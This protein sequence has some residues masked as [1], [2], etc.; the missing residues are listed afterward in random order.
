MSLDELPLES[1]ENALLIFLVGGGGGGAITLFLVGEPVV[2]GGDHGIAG[3]ELVML[4]KDMVLGGWGSA[5]F[6]SFFG[7]ESSSRSTLSKDATEAC[8]TRGE[9]VSFGSG[10]ASIGVSP[11]AFSLISPSP[12]GSA[13]SLVSGRLC[14]VFRLVNDRTEAVSGDCASSKVSCIA[15]L[16]SA[17]SGYSGWTIE[18]LR[19]DDVQS[20]C[21]KDRA[22]Q[23]QAHRPWRSGARI[24][25]TWPKQAEQLGVMQS[26]KQRNR[27]KGKRCTAQ[28]RRDFAIK[29]DPGKGSQPSGQWYVRLSISVVLV[30]RNSCTPSGDQSS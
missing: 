12:S 16:V 15:K 19:R 26:R 7:A 10:T 29:L 13:C 28:E 23:V 6:L 25:P 22:N 30:T 21:L 20:P 3:R 18:P 9:E 27:V 1:Q 24:D 11:A 5:V 2:A 17:E 14:G 8:D 4:V